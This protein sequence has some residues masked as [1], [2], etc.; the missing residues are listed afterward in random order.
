[1]E[2][3]ILGKNIY[4]RIVNNYD[5]MQRQLFSIG[6]TLPVCIARFSGRKSRGKAGPSR[7][8]LGLKGQ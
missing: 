4:N 1:M 2:R 8:S 5:K 6:K 7:L 3:K